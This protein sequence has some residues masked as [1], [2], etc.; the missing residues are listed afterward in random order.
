[1]NRLADESSPYLRQHA[2]NPVDW[3]P[4]GDEAF[5]AARERDVPILLSVGYSACHWCHVMAHESFEDDEVAAAM[6]AAFVNV[7][8]DR[9]E[10]PDVDGLYMEA[11]QA[12]TGRGGWPMTVALY[13]DGRPFWGGT[14]FPKDAMLQ[15]TEAI[16]TAWTERRDQLEENAEQLIEAIGKRSGTEP[17]DELPSIELV[18]DTIRKIGAAFDG[19]WGG[20]GKPPKFPNAHHVQL[21]LRAFMSNQQ[22]DPKRVLTTT[23]DAMA[24]G[25]MYDHIAG[26]FARYST[27]RQWLVP[28][29]EKMLYD[30]AMLVSTY[31]QAFTVLGRPAYRQ[32]VTETIEYVL[33]EL[34]LPD[35]GFATSQDAD[36]IAADGTSQEGWFQTWTPDEVRAALAG[37]DPELADLTIEWFGITDDGNFEGRS[38]PNR[39]HARG[40]LRRPPALEVARRRL[41]EI[42]GHRARPALDDKVVTEWNGWFLAA[43][44]DA[45]M[46]FRNSRWRD[47]AVANGE[48][49]LDHLRDDDGRW[50][51]VWHAEGR[52]QARHRALAGDQAALLEAFLELGE[53]TGQARWVDAA[54]EVADVLLD[55]HFD[56]VQG[57]LDTTADDAESLVVRR[58]DLLDG[59]GPSANSSAAVGLMRLAAITGELRYANH[60]DRILQLLA[61]VVPEA[62][63][64]TSNALMAIELRQRGLMELVIPGESPA[65][66]AVAQTLWR[67]DLVLAWGERF[68]SPIWEGREDG[69]A[70]LCRDRVCQAP[71]TTAE[72]LFEQVTGRPLPD[73][74]TLPES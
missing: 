4:W 32:V 10:R 19:E 45:A 65:M 44:A 18:N 56:P 37:A 42:R 22:D 62:P 47:A 69:R 33:R 64:A 15:V 43:L 31:R 1:M 59:T 46:T 51:R 9:E 61:A 20:F 17:D 71:A 16:T 57:G 53:L 3:Y 14:Y 12:M 21:I 6:N 29:F 73:G 39:L 2:D 67:P 26:G 24:S 63:A 5:E 66:V 8:V 35:G 55:R 49:L 48:F 23:L 11:V 36:S 58:K 38:I 50:W 30:Q 74:V 34:R 27:D 40:E 28:H 13:P 60:A 54:R 72:Q 70:Y 68:D 25:G 52:P 41:L 7:K